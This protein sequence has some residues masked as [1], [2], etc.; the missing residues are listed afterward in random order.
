MAGRLTHLQLEGWRVVANDGVTR[1]CA[2]GEGGP[3]LARLLLVDGRVGQEQHRLPAVFEL[4]K[5]LA[6]GNK[7]LA[8]PAQG[9][10]H[11]LR[12]EERVEEK[13]Q[14]VIR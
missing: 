12:E 13:Q 6:E 10:A 7:S 14:K 9:V 11:A 2:V 4:L 8:H 5:V 1:D 3:P